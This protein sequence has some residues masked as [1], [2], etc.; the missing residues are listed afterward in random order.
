MP[1]REGDAGR[2]LRPVELDLPAHVRSALDLAEPGLRSNGVAVVVHT[3]PALRVEVDAD[4]LGQVLANL[5][6]NAARYT[7][8]GGSV[9]VA[10]EPRSR[11]RGLRAPRST[12]PVQASR[13]P[14][15]PTSS[16]ASTGSISRVRQ[17]AAAQV[18]DWP[19][20]RSWS[21]PGEAR[22]ARRRRTDAPASG[23]PSPPVEACRTVVPHW[24]HDDPLPGSVGSTGCCCSPARGTGCAS[25]TLRRRTRSSTPSTHS[26]TNGWPPTSPRRSVVRRCTPPDTAIIVHAAHPRGQRSPRGARRGVPDR[27]RPGAAQVGITGDVGARVSTYFRRRPS[28]SA[29]TPMAPIS[30]P[31]VSSSS[32]RRL[33]ANPSAGGLAREVRPPSP[34]RGPGCGR[35][36]AGPGTGASR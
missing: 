25:R 12:T 6:S 16:S 28:P 15:Y 13:P 32:G 7:P 17:P 27:L 14:T 2:T 10:V 26:T 18:S 34:R 3:P 1:S 31:M 30:S 24:P 4:A 33:A 5:L 20:W 29:A 36:C 21:T 9:D 8:P 22:W 11:E 35:P 23:S 19:S